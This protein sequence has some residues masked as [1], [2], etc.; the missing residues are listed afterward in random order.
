VKVRIPTPLYS[1]TAS[2]STVDATGVTVDAVT[3]DLD[4]QFPGIRFRFIDEQDQIRPHVKI[5][6]NGEQVRELS[7]VAASDELAIVQAFSGG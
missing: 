7:K 2:R 3:R 6:L 1:Y 4:R 5:F